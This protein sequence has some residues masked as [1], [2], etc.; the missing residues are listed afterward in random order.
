MDDIFEAVPPA[1][2]IVSLRPIEREDLGFLR[3]LAN[4]PE[5]RRNVVGWGWPLSLADQERW[6]NSGIDT[7]TTRRLIVETTDRQPI[8]MTGLWEIDWR[9]RS[10]M[11]AIKLGGRPGIRGKGLG[12]ATIQAVTEFAFH[13]VGLR[14]LHAS[15]LASNEASR[16]LFVR[17]CRWIEEGVMREHVWREGEFRDVVQVGILDHEYEQLRG[18]RTC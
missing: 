1:E 7:P 17:K 14:R 2:N 10:A 11:V 4:D 8:G 12:V 16:A 6:F 15:F 18:A 3:D 5:V 13:D 9:N